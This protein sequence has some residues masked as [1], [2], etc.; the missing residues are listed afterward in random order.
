MNLYWKDFDGNEKFVKRIDPRKSHKKTTYSSYIFIVRDKMDVRLL[1]FTDYVLTSV[2]YDG[3]IFSA[4]AG[5]NE[6]TIVTI[7]DV[8]SFNK[9]KVST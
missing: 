8:G 6:T 4:C 9:H 7:K 5:K 3:T 1:H 2:I